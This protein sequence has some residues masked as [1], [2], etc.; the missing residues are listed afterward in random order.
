MGKSHMHSC[1]M[2]GTIHNCAIAMLSGCLLEVSLAQTRSRSETGAEGLQGA[3][4]RSDGV[5]ERTMAA[6]AAWASAQPGHVESASDAATPPLE[7]AARLVPEDLVPFVQEV[8]EFF[9]F[10]VGSIPW[11]CSRS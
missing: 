6:A 5:D 1:A 2:H 8:V 3:G 11:G 4:K 7:L 10:T 9:F